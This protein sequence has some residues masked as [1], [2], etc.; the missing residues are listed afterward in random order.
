V[1]Q[2]DRAIEVIRG[3]RAARITAVNPDGS[4]PISKKK[5]G[6]LVG[7]PPL[8]G[9]TR[10]AQALPDVGVQKRVQFGQKLNAG[11]LE[12]VATPVDRQKRA[13][14]SAP[15]LLAA[16]EG[17][18]LVF[19]A[20][21]W[22]AARA[23]G[24]AYRS[25]PKSPR[26]AAPHRWHRFHKHVHA[27]EG[28]SARMQAEEALPGWLSMVDTSIRHPHDGCVMRSPVRLC[29]SVPRRPTSVLRQGCEGHQ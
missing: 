19:I 11:G 15:R 13:A 3:R 22:V 2:P 20:A 9:L 23:Q 26:S 25:S 8:Q 7:G 21:E 18:D 29:K 27:F 12:P 16:L 24:A 28:A 17:A 5:K 6:G 14:E 10:D 4:P 1:P